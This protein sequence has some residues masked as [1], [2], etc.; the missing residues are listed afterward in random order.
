MKQFIYIIISLLIVSCGN[1]NSTSGYNA[2]GQLVLNF[3]NEMTSTFF[4]D[5]VFGRVKMIPLETS[6]NSLVGRGPDLLSDNQHYFVWDKQQH[7][8]IRFDE[9]GKYINR[10]GSRGAGP[11]EYILILDYY[12][13]TTSA[14]VEILAPS[15][16]I[17]RYN[18]DGQFISS[19]TY[20]NEFISFTKTGTDYWFYLGI[21]PEA[22]EGRLIKISE[23][24]T[25]IQ[26]FLPVKTIW[27]LPW[28]I[29]KN[30]TQC[31]NM[32]V[33]NEY[34]SHN[35]YSIT[36]DGPIETTI[37]NFGKYDIPNNIFEDDL[38]KVFDILSDKGCALIC[39]FIE[40]ERFVY[41]HFQTVKGDDFNGDYH[42]LVNKHTGNSVL[43]KFSLDDPLCM[44]M[45]EARLMTVNN[46][47]VFMVEAQK[48]KECTDPFIGQAAGSIKDALSEDDNP[49]I[50]I[51]T[52]NDF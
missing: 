46:E 29:V 16:Q 11:G 38:E 15:G 52:M 23:D 50:I 27:P 51:L 18:Y 26:N 24:G 17:L 44:L 14:T 37:L 42:W 32:I 48:L 25:D 7:F 31:G 13:D 3:E 1:E 4:S 6:D 33:F 43:Q 28:A 12:I 30:F 35:V 8:I 22:E 20:Q 47:L 21:I 2:A 40:N 10:I 19:H 5:R 49:V 41:V 39:E 45:D 9:T 36:D 34:I